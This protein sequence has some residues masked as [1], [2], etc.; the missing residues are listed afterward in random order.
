MTYLYYKHQ[1]A[2]TNN[3]WEILVQP[4]HSKLEFLVYAT[5]LKMH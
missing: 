5:S 3:L 2:H 1:N 4:Y